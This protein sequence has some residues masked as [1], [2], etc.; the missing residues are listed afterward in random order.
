MIATSLLFVY[1][2]C[3]KA[4]VAK[5]CADIVKVAFFDLA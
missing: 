1:S 3:K 4:I 5:I 2:S